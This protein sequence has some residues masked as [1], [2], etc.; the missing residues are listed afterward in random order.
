MQNAPGEYP[1]LTLS[2]ERKHY[3]AE[4]SFSSEPNRDTENM[5]GVTVLKKIRILRDSAVSTQSAV[6]L[7]GTVYEVYRVY[8]GTDDESGEQI[9]DISLSKVIEDY[10]KQS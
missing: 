7:D 2:S 4:L 1:I 9:T 3:F 6:E 10:E 5:E 8:H